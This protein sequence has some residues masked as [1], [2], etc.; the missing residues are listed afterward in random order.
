MSFPIRLLAVVTT[1]LFS[2]VISEMTSTVRACLQETIKARLNL[3]LHVATFSLNF[4]FQ[5][6]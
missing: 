6:N 2:M 4:K 5:K 1:C 3:R